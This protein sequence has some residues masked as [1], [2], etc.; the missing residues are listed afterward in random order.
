MREWIHTHHKLFVSSTP[1][2]WWPNPCLKNSEDA[3]SGCHGPSLQSQHYRCR[4]NRLTENSEPA[5]A[6]VSP[7]LNWLNKT[8]THKFWRSTIVGL[9]QKAIRPTSTLRLPTGKEQGILTGKGILNSPSKSLTKW[10][11]FHYK[12]FKSPPLEQVVEKS[13]FHSRLPVPKE[14]PPSQTLQN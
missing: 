5:W 1:H 3:R 8:K 13:K 12:W 7:G 10:R 11:F 6:T 2:L 9:H 4:S 14:E